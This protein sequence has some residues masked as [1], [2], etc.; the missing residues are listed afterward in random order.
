MYLSSHYYQY[1]LTN[2]AGKANANIKKQSMNCNDICWKTYL[3][4]LFKSNVE[5]K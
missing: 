5:N 4:N 3:S 2:F 1:M